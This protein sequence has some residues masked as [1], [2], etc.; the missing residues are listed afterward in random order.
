MANPRAVTF[1]AERLP[2]GLQHPGDETH[3]PFVIP[4]PIGSSG[5]PPELADHFAAAAGM[6]SSDVP[7][8]VGEALVSMLE[9]DGEFTILDNTELAELRQAAADAPDGTRIVTLKCT[10]HNH[11]VIELTVD[12]SDEKRVNVKHLVLALEHHEA[13]K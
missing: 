4:L 3:K 12:K 6:P 8:L 7:K 10:C 2:H 11:P 5:I 9:T 1:L 13:T